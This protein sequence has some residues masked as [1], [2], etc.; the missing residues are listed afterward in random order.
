MLLLDR[1]EAT[2]KHG[3]TIRMKRSGAHPLKAGSQNVLSV[4]V[5]WRNDN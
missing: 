1:A 3:I 2:G 4:R 5:E